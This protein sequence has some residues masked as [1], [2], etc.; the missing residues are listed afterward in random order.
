MFQKLFEKLHDRQKGT[1][2]AQFPPDVYKPILRKSI[3]TGETTAGFR[4][5][6]TGKY[7]EVMLIRGEKDLKQF[8]SMYGVTEQPE[9][10]Y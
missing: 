4:N 7:T 10:E 8:M 5:L 9:T 3:C 6:E 1:M 2:T